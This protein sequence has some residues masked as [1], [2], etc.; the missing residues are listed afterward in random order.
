[1]SKET[2]G[3]LLLAV[4]GICFI[5]YVLAMFRYTWPGFVYGNHRDAGSEQRQQ[6]IEE[7]LASGPS[8]AIESCAGRLGGVTLNGPLLTVDVRPSG[9]VVSPFPGR[10]AIKADQIKELR[11][12]NGFWTR[13]LCI[14]HTSRAIANPILLAGIRED[15]HFA[16]T[17]R[18]IV[19]KQ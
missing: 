5:I 13:G 14:V 11:Y 7:V 12:E 6:V 8:L 9:I 1:M 16:R 3:L 15:S 19:D 18:T 2:C 4:G 10:S 17:L